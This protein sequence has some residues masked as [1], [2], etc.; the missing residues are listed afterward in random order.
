MSATAQDAAAQ[1]VAA[2]RWD[3]IVVG[4]RLGELGH[5]VLVLEAGRQ[6]SGT[7]QAHREAVRA[8]HEAV[9]KVPNSP[10]LTTVRAV[11]G[12][13][14]A[15]LG[16]EDH[17]RH[18]PGPACPGHFEYRGRS[19]GY[20]GAGHGGGTHIMGDSPATSVVDQ[21]QRC[22]DHPNLYAVGCGSMPSLGTSNPSLTMAA[23]ALRSA[24]RMHREPAGA[25]TY[26]SAPGA[27]HNRP[28]YLP[29]KI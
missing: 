4:A 9:V 20:R 18:E 19:Y 23:L 29:P 16:A 11:S 27:A 21:W 17:T 26:Q 10:Y 5:R 6:T 1:E 14:F 12:Q 3:A 7:D 13:I 25:W 15:L 28:Y 22:W 2:R 8:F 24:D